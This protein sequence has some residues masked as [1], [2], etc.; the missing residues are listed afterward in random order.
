VRSSGPRGSVPVTVAAL[1]ALFSGALLAFLV[2]VDFG[3]VRLERLR[4]AAEDGRVVSARLW[5]PVAATSQP[6]VLLV[7]GEGYDA[8]AMTPLALELARRGYVVLAVDRPSRGGLVPR[9]VVAA[10]TGFEA[11]RALASVDGER[12]ALV[13]HGD[14]ASGVVAAAA[15]AAP[16]AVVLLGASA[17]VAEVAPLPNVALVVGRFD[18]RAQR[19]WGSPVEL[20]RFPALRALFGGVPEVTPRDLYGDIAAG[21]GRVLHLPP[22]THGGLLSS[23]QALAPVIDWLQ[24]TAPVAAPR[25]PNE[26]TWIGWAIG[27]ALVLAGFVTLLF[28]LA[29]SLLSTPTFAPL[30]QRPAAGVGLTGAGWWLAGALATAVPALTF[31]WALERFGAL[32]LPLVAATVA[33]FLVNAA[34]F[35]AVLLAWHLVAGRRRGATAASYG[36]ALPGLARAV[37]LGLATVAA[38]HGALALAASLFAV[39]GRLAGL[40]QPALTPA[41]LVVVALAAP[42]LALGFGLAGVLLHGFLRPLGTIREGLDGAVANALV[43]SGGL[44]TLLGLQVAAL[45]RDGTTPFSPEVGALAFELAPAFALAAL[46]STTLFGRTGSVWPGAFVNALWIA[47]YLAT[48]G[49]A[50]L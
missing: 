20:T 25:P 26:Q 5:R 31:P 16:A 24:R 40:A 28:G 36:A 10:V 32:P 48:R 3:G 35:L 49:S 46:L 6:G 43:A 12:L 45:L 1:L 30:E 38:A 33:W 29:G 27:S 15:A 34:L 14:G 37:G 19:V 9:S 13:G 11:L 22:L 39:D 41:D 44:L 18:D 50:L 2:Q 8:V 47:G 7:P 17:S 23:G 4:L 21:T 42:P